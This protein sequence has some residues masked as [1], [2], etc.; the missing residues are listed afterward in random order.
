MNIIKIQLTRPVERITDALISYNTINYIYLTININ[1]SVNNN[2]F[3][4]N[5]LDNSIKV[6]IFAQSETYLVLLTIIKLKLWQM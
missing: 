6:I 2:K 1:K 3:T 5:Y 4:P